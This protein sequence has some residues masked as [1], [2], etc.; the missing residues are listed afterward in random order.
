MPFLSETVIDG[1]PLC[2]ESGTLLG[3]DLVETLRDQDLQRG[4]R[5]GIRQSEGFSRSVAREHLRSLDMIAPK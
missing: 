3:R 5:K 4:I 2:I 1:R